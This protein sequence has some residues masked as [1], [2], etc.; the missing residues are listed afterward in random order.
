MRNLTLLL[1]TFRIILPLSSL[2]G[3]LGSICAFYG[4]F[5]GDSFLPTPIAILFGCANADGCARMAY[6]TVE[7]WK[8]W[9]VQ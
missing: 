8:R 2:F 7:A 4:I 9:R 3:A 5:R 6:H 1:W